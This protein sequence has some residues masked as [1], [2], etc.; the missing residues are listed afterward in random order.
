M[1][2]PMRVMRNGIAGGSA[3]LRLFLSNLETEFPGFH[4]LND[5]SS[6]HLLQ[7]ESISPLK[8]L[9]LTR[10]GLSLQQVLLSNR[11]A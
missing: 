3:A 9:L 1:S 5:I 11:V 2:V 10:G 6:S 7:M 4:H 8:Q